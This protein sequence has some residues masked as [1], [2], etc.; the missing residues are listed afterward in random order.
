MC[1]ENVLGGNENTFWLLIA[2]SA[3]LV[4][5]FIKEDNTRRSR[6]LSEINRLDERKVF[7][8]RSRHEKKVVSIFHNALSLSSDRQE[9][10]YPLPKIKI[11]GGITALNGTP[12]RLE[13][14][15]LLASGYLKIL[16]CFEGEARSSPKHDLMIILEALRT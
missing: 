1:Y 11:D 10:K 13:H 15:I 9:C 14:R 16:L 2:P 3:N 12:S 7:I 4:E 8:V 5:Y 6:G